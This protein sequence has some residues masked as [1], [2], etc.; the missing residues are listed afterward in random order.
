VKTNQPFYLKINAGRVNTTAPLTIE[1]TSTAF[2][3]TPKCIITD[4]GHPNN[5]ADFNTVGQ[6]I[7]FGP[8]TCTSSATFKFSLKDAGT[9]IG[10]SE[11]SVSIGANAMKELVISSPQNSPSIAP[12]VS[13]SFD[14]TAMGTNGFPYGKFTSPV[15]I[16]I[17]GDTAA[18]NEDVLTIGTAAG[19]DTK[20][21]FHIT[22]SKAGTFTLTARG[23][24][25][26]S[27]PFTVT[28][29]GV[30]ATA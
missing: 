23:G 28:V 26:T 7:V 3:G 14:V 20:K 4:A 8:V 2:N 13:A 15:I 19:G 12:G 24:T 30:T 6:A 5:T 17:N 18:K 29:A 22:F 11:T 21:T 1:L 25:F 27:A 16:L 10:S 9:E